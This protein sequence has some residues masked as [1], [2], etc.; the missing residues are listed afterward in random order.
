[1]F[2]LRYDFYVLFNLFL[3]LV[4]PVLVGLLGYSLHRSQKIPFGKRG[5]GR[6]PISFLVGIGLTAA[7]IGWYADMNPM[8]SPDLP[9][10]TDTS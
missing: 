2:Y 4:G 6:F 3:I 10:K 7:S 5:W 9:L 8:V 1:M